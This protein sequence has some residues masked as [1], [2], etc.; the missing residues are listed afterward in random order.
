MPLLLGTNLP[1][2]VD[3]P[4]KIAGRY[5]IT[6]GLKTNPKS[7]EY[8][9]PELIGVIPVTVIPLENSCAVKS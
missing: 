7:T 1:F 3:D 2:G 6:E 5:T 4:P 9:L 8:P